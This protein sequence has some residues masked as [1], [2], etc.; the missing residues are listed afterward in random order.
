MLKN[1]AESVEFCFNALL[2]LSFYRLLSLIRC[3]AVN[4]RHALI[5]LQTL[6]GS[7]YIYLYL[8]IYYMKYVLCIMLSS[9]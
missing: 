5:S 7:V 4:A 8:Y 1:I 2:D 9:H 3:T 6:V